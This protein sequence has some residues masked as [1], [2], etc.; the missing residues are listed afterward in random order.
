VCRTRCWNVS[1]GTLVEGINFKLAGFFWEDWEA[2]IVSAILSPVSLSG[3]FPPRIG[4]RAACTR[5]A[6]EGALGTGLRIPADC[7]PG[8]PGRP[9]RPEA[10]QGCERTS[11]PRPTLHQ[12]SRDYNNQWAH[13]TV[14]RDVEHRLPDWGKWP[15]HRKRATPDHL[16]NRKWRLQH[17]AVSD[18]CGE[19]RAAGKCLSPTDRTSI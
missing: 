19:T 14:T 5:F 10:K 12:G 7:R 9:E 13:S 4:V 16:M 18:S 2:R 3:R 11:P 15:A 8:H 17:R 6:E 1:Q